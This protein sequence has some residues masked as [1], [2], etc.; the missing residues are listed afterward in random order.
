MLNIYLHAAGVSLYVMKLQWSILNKGQ[1][2]NYEQQ[3]LV[4][5]RTLI[6]IKDKKR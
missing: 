3:K 2:F 1:K 4:H 5:T 6:H